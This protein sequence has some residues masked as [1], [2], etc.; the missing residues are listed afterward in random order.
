[1]PQLQ[2]APSPDA[3][4]LLIVI[5]SSA[6]VGLITNP[7]READIDFTYEIAAT[8]AA[9]RE[10]LQQNT[11]DAVLSVQGSGDASSMTDR[12]AGRQG[13]LEN[14]PSHPLTDVPSS[15]EALELVQQSGQFIPL[16]AI[17]PEAEIADVG[18]EQMKH[19]PK[20]LMRSLHE[21][22]QHRIERDR[23]VKIQQQAQREAII[24]RIVQAMRET[25]VLEEVLQT[26]VNLLHEALNLSRCLIFLPDPNQQMQACLASESTPQR[27]SLIGVYCGFY[28]YYHSSL[29]Q[30]EP[31]IFNQIDDRIPLKLQELAREYEVC[32]MLTMPM[33]YQQSLVGGISLH[34]CVSERQWTED[35]I[36]LVSA[37]ANQCAIAIHQAQLFDRVQQQATREQLLNNICRS[38]NSSLDPQYILQEIVNLTGEFFGVDRVAIFAL[39]PE[40]IKI[41]KEWRV[42][43]QVVSVLNLKFPRSENPDVLAPSSNYSVHQVFHA[44]KI[45]D[46]A[47][48][49][50]REEQIRQLQIL[51]MVRVP[52]FIRGQIFGGISLQSTT[53]YR[54]FTEDEIHLLKRIADQVAIALYNAQSYEASE[55]L[56]KE[57][58]QQLEQEK[59]LSEAANRAK[60]EFIATMSH[61]LR[62]PLTS[63]LG[64]S[65]LLVDQI[66]GSLN[67]KQQEY[68]TLITSGGEHLLELIND[69]L[70][71]SLIDAGR[72]EFSLEIL[73][74]EEVCQASI[75]AV[76]E[77]AQNKGLQLIVEISPGIT[78]CVGDHRRLKKILINL[79][80]NAVKF[81]PVGSVTLKVEKTTDAILFSV[82]DTGIGIAKANHATLFEPFRQI[83][84]GLNRQYEGTGLGL[85]LSRKLAFLHGGNITVDSELGQGSCFTLHLPIQPP[86]ELNKA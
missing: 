70:D 71:L 23:I 56:V 11:Y 7:L 64:L 62:T 78:T 37:I 47:S 52:I 12:K 6:D 76:R 5:A 85:A 54:T 1:M 35:E 16:I 25:L 68:L 82:I 46:I 17:A 32:S 14:S 69:L 58:T 57:R 21:F 10:Q 29:A 86:D 34:Q 43:E 65:R 27:Q 41:L 74:V 60:S 48:S 18:S 31:L 77:P 4:R 81:T 19:L 42:S 26:T 20:I 2:Q 73:L 51:S 3:L 15:L 67:D 66:V 39:E 53:R 63:I 9:C 22:E 30:G 40:E 72:E 36:A 49:P 28:S 13:K 55:Q 61:E 24:N 80:S 75:S 79:L 44:P 8:S 38:L 83:D 33:L 84:S 59:Q 45:A 50:N